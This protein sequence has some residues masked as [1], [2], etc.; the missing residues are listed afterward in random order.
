[1]PDHLLC[2]IPKTRL[3]QNKEQQPI[4]MAKIHLQLIREILEKYHQNS[5]HHERTGNNIFLAINKK[6]FPVILYAGRKK[7]NSKVRR[8]KN[9]SKNDKRRKSQYECKNCNV[10]LCTDSC[11]RIYHTQLYY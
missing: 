2:W 5:I 3:L 8:L 4:S 9:D 7:S 1:M 10:G 11:F 6:V